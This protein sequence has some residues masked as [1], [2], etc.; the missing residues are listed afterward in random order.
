MK[1]VQDSKQVVTQII[2]G[3]SVPMIQPEIY[4]RIYCKNCEFEVDSEEQAIGTCS[5][6]GQP[7]SLYKA[8]DIHVKVIEM[9]GSIGSGTGE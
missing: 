8:K 5:E 6:C 7:W 4:Q 1:K 2:D 3:V 9:P